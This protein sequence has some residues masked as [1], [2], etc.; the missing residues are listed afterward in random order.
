MPSVRASVRACEP[1]VAPQAK[2]REQFLMTKWFYEYAGE[3][4]GPVPQQTVVHLARH[5]AI[6]PRT[7]VWNG[8]D[9]T[10]TELEQLSFLQALRLNE[11]PEC[12]ATAPS[13]SVRDILQRALDAVRDHA[14]DSLQQAKPTIWHCATRFSGANRVALIEYRIPAVE[15]LGIESFRSTAGSKTPLRVYRAVVCAFVCAPVTW[16][17][18]V[19]EL[20]KHGKE[21]REISIEYECIEWKDGGWALHEISRDRAKGR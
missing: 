11:G 19:E 6:G 7:R 4:L 5:G 18:T 17:A 16:E 8:E 12:P 10:P 20:R 13:L 9:A 21:K 14:E 15:Q 3:K 1:V 2:H